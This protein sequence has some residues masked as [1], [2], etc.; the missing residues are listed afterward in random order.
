MSMY[1]LC[2]V[3]FLHEY[4]ILIKD[5]DSLISESFVIGSGYLERNLGIK[6]VG[7]LWYCQ[8]LCVVIVVE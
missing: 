1:C 8:L 6:W 2:I 4:E 3:V 5:R 7:F